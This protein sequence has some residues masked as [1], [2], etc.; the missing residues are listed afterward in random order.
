M[1]YGKNHIE[2]LLK[3]DVIHLI[4][5]RLQ[6]LYPNMEIANS[7][8][9]KTN[10]PSYLYCLKI[11]DHPPIELLFPLHRPIEK[12]VIGASSKHLTKPS[13]ILF[14]KRINTIVDEL[15]KN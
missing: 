1:H 4:L 14:T 3:K 12:F 11:P 8:V 10:E 9:T 6:S 7:S 5:D 15:S 13:V 2:Q